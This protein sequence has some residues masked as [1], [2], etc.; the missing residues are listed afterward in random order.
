MVFSSLE[1]LFVFLPVF[2]FIYYLVPQR[3]R[4]WPLLL[5]S[6][7]FY[8]YGAR[9]HPWILLLFFSLNLLA[10]VIGSLMETNPSQRK[11]LLI[12]ALCVIFGS[13]LGFKYAGFFTGTIIL[14]PLGISF[15]SFQLAAYLIDVQQ[16][17]LKAERSFFK[18]MTAM[19]LFPKLISGPLTPYDSLSK[20]LDQ[21]NFSWER[22]NY[23]LQDFV[24]GLAM[25]CLLAD[26]IGGL[27]H[28]VQTIGF[29]SLSTPLAWLGIAAFSLQLYFDF[30][31]YSLM[32]I[33]LGRMIG[34][35]LPKNF[36]LPY[37]S[38]SMTEFWRRWHITLGRW[39]LDYVYIPLGG[40]REGKGKELR[41]LLIVWLL[42]GIWHG[43]TPNFVLWGLFIF[44][45]IA[46]EKL[47]LE[48]FLERHRVVSHT[49]LIVTI[50]LS[51]MLFAITDLSQ[52]A[53]YLGRLFPFFGEWL[54]I[55]DFLRLGQQYGI[56]LVLGI[57]VS[58]SWFMRCWDNIR[59]TRWGT[60]TLLV[61]FWLSVYCLSAGLND[62][63]LYFSF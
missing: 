44:V 46:I 29:T 55:T 16:R 5:G 43:A 1:F 20:Q 31:G 25:K 19:L 40:S 37:T 13:L 24:F 56:F 7:A 27:W 48:A 15:Y 45:L 58:T 28:Q 4:N 54:P 2:L 60:I 22:F 47:W 41:N 3:F 30:Y 39:F 53:T 11:G 8:A 59:Q 26:Q 62:P 21:R 57:L 61:L 50:M 51:W 49:Y 14:L 10:Y 6:I 36:I 32:A 42:T 18:L 12:G 38:R 63:F 9:S 33:G 17:R 35:R 34:F 23:G 52:I